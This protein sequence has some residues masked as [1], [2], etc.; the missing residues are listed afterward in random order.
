MQPLATQSAL[1]AD[2]TA[3]LRSY[4]EYRARK[5]IP[6]LDGLRAISIL[7]VITWHMWDRAAFWEW[8]RG[9][10]GVRIFF[11]LS[12]YL[13]TSLLLEEESKR[14]KVSLPAFYV[15]RSCRI[16]PLY[17]VILL[18]YCVLIY[19]FSPF[20]AKRAEM[21]YAMPYLLFYLQEIPF[22]LH[23]VGVWFPF[24]QSWSLGIEEKFYLVWPVAA[25]VLLHGCRQWRLALG[26]GFAAL[27]AAL[28]LCRLGP[29]TSCVFDYYTIL[30]GCCTAV[31]LFEKRHYERLKGLGSALGGWCA[32]GFLVATHFSIERLPT[33][34]IA[35]LYPVAV[36]LFMISLLAGR[37]PFGRAL[38]CAPLVF[39]GK[40]SYGMYLVHLLCSN[41]ANLVFRPGSGK[42][43]IGVLAYLLA[44]ALCIAASKALAVAIEQPFIRLGHKWSA[45]ILGKA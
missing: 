19:G 21:D 5:Y 25:F 17:Y 29:W 11:V 1:V 28:P 4:E 34:F 24:Y 45:R 39:I 14:G 44:C 35:R 23:P 31:V 12:G 20:A 13:I 8:L 18:V 43:Y 16:F 2:E 10:E 27:F 15:R 32:F 6:E 42:W 9:G 38:G 41:A 30:V 3:P 26:V 37:G 7:L 22:Y 40:I 36:A 33:V